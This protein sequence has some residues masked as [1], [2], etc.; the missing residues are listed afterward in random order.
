MYDEGQGVA[1]DYNEA[2]SWYLKAAA[3]GNAPAQ[4]NLG[5]MCA[6]GQGAA[7]DVIEAHKWFA[8][9]AMQGYPNARKFQDTLERKM[10]A[11]QMAESR[12]RVKEWHERS[13][14]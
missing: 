1:Q 7:P 2:R 12:R 8:L 5:V 10:T 6:Q 11:A 4:F 14:R 13:G 3:Q 9:A